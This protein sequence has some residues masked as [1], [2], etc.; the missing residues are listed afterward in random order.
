VEFEWDETKERRNVRKHGVAFDEAAE[1]FYDLLG[2]ERPD[3]EHS[4]TE[5][6]WIRLARSERDRLLVT[7]F[8]ERRNGIR[9][10]SSRRATRR[11]VKTY[12]EGV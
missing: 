10:V 2:L 5:D 6:R 12:E 8:V 1:T 4:K 3:P 7:V 11:E 9:I